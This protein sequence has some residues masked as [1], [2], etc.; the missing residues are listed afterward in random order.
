ME[1]AGNFRA[2]GAVNPLKA[3]DRNEETR[4]ENSDW[5]RGSRRVVCGD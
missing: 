5:Y 2:A 3:E 1:A 4:N